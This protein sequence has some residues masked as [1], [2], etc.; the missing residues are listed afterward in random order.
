MLCCCPLDKIPCVPEFI[1][2]SCSGG[3]YTELDCWGSDSGG[4]LRIEETGGGPLTPSGEG[5][6]GA[7]RDGG[8]EDG[9]LV[10]FIGELIRATW[11]PG[12]PPPRG[13]WSV[14][15]CGEYLY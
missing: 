12:G 7:R 1:G 4:M 6:C 15:V 13:S 2:G 14:C 3:R 11:C 9:F 10:E 8:S 5:V